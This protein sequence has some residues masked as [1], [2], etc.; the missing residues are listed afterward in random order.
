MA[1]REGEDAS[2]KIR[3]QARARAGQL[4]KDCQSTA[5]QLKSARSGPNV[6]ATPL[7]PAMIAILHTI[8]PTISVTTCLT[9]L[10]AALVHE[11][12]LQRCYEAALAEGRAA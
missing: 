3:V 5:E 1:A 2:G 12:R 10:V 11:V 8:L 9:L 6:R 7:V 4:P